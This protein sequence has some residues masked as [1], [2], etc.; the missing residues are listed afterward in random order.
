MR[1]L[2]LAFLILLIP[3]LA[4]S[5]QF[6][7]LKEG[8]ITAA[9][10]DCSNTTRCVEVD[11]N[12][13]PGVA[14]LGVFVD[15]GTSATLNFEITLNNTT[16]IAI[17]D[18]INAAT[19]VT[20]D[21]VSFFTNPGFR[22]FR[23]RASALSGA[24]TITIVRGWSNLRS[25]ATLSG[26]S[27][28]DGAIQDGASSAIEATVLD[29][30]TSNPLAVHL[31]DATGATASV[32]GGTQYTQGDTDAS[33]T[34]TAMLM[35]VASDV[36]QPVQGTVADGLLV[37]LGTNNDVTITTSGVTATVLNFAGNDGLGVA[38]L[39]ASGNQITS[40]GGGVQY[41]ETDFDT[42]ITGTAMM[43]ETANVLAPAVGAIP[44]DNFANPNNAL[45]VFSLNGC[46]DGTAWD[47]CT[48][49]T[50]TADTEMSTAAA[51]ADGMANPTAGGALVFNMVWNGTTWDRATESLL[52]ETAHDSPLGTLT[53]IRALS[54]GHRA[55]NFSGV[56]LAGGVGA[57][58][59]MILSAATFFG[60]QY[61]M[62]VTDDGSQIGQLRISDGTDNALVDASGNLQVL[63]ANCSGSGVSDV[64]DSTFTVATDAVVPSAFLFDDTTPDSV[65]EGDVGV[66]RMTA[67]RS[68]HIVI[69]D[70]QGNERS[71]A[72]D[73]GFRLQVWDQ[74]SAVFQDDAAFAAGTNSGYPAMGYATTDAVNAGDIGAIG[75]TTLRELFGVIRDGAGNA[76]AANVNASNELLVAIGALPA[77]TNNIG[78]VDVLT[79]PVAFNAGTASATTLRTVTASDSHEFVGSTGLK[80]T[81]VGSTEDEHAVK[82]TAGVLRSVLITNTNAAARYF[83][84]SNAVA[85]STT[86]GTTTPVIDLAIPGNTAGSGFSIPLPKG[87][88][89]ST[90]LTCWLVTGAADNNTDEVAANEIK[91]LYTFD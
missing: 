76:R 13:L 6:V 82:A 67:F 28:G 33:I 27:Q 8:I 29:F 32:G 84:C 15:V 19:S 42:T 81:S 83:R 34:G 2:I 49:S 85:G 22:R 86:P 54:T 37:N 87:F 23:V 36:V 20:A 65:D 5:Q 26:S 24:S 17:A 78:D 44:I 58:N 66:G 74:N 62:L 60:V 12:N 10:A 1:K 18:D 7:V 4:E 53:S 70:G 35:E 63:C 64:D 80:Y 48:G 55:V 71:A 38:I 90:A 51:A 9:G 77:G 56:P 3:S 89:F 88:A 25:T 16:W 91:I 39:D 52:S 40:F 14:S 50:T 73:S 11:L 61:M 47:R 75:M 68:Q 21:G 79:L 57:N 46:W 41:T 69:R 59:D 30:T 72:V 43:L 31:V 45:V